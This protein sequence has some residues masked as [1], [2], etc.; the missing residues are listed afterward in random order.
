MDR[1]CFCEEMEKGELCEN[2]ERE[3]FLEQ[4]DN[5]YEKVREEW[6]S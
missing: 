2:C 5:A 4:R 6:G 1:K 3:K